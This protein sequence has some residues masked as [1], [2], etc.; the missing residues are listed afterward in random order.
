MKLYSY[1]PTFESADLDYVI[2]KCHS[3]PQ[4][5]FH[6]FSAYNIEHGTWNMGHLDLYLNQYNNNNIQHLYSAL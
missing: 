1:P 6:D 2:P 4:L 5:L 3:R